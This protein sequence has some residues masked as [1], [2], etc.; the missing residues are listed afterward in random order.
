[1]Q[2]WIYEKKKSETMLSASILKQDP[3]PQTVKMNVNLNRE[4]TKRTWAHILGKS[5]FTK[6]ANQQKVN[7][8]SK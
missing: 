7:N 4:N 3:N 5:H 1:M 2:V 6:G 8:K